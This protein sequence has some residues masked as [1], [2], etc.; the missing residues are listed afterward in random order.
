[1]AEFK[2]TQDAF[3]IKG[4]RVW[5][6]QLN[7]PDVPTYQD[8]YR[9]RS[10]VRFTGVDYLELNVDEARALRDWLTSVLPE[11]MKP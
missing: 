8:R 11:P 6:T 3:A 9:G 1:M 4:G 5:V 10:L 2:E 7:I